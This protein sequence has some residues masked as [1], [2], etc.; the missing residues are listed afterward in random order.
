MRHGLQLPIFFLGI[1]SIALACGDPKLPSEDGNDDVGDGDGDGDGD[2]GSQLQLTVNKD[3][4]ILFVIDNTGSMGEEQARL[5]TSVGAFIDVLE[6]P[7]VA[8]NYRIGVTTTDNGNPWCPAGTTTPEAGKLV[9]SSCKNRLGDFLFSDTVDVQDLACNDICTLSDAELEIIPTTTDYD[10]NQV[11]RPWLENI[12][13]EKN[14]PAN[15]SMADACRWF[16]SPLESMYLSLA[17]A[18]N[19]NEANYGFLRPTAILAIVIVSDEADCSYNKDFADIFAQD[20][21]KVFWSDPTASFPTSAV[22]WNAGVECS[23]D[24]SGYDSCEPVN[25]DVNGTAGVSDQDAVLHPMSRYVGRIQGIEDQKKEYNAT[26]EVITVLIGGVASDGS[27]VYADAIDP[28]FQD[29]FGIGPGCTD[30]G[31]ASAVPPVRMRSFTEAFSPESMYSICESDYTPAFEAIADAI[32]DQIK[33]ACY[34]QCAADTM[35]ATEVID[36][37]CVVEEN[38]PALE[39]AEIEECMRNG[40]GSYAIDPMTMSHA[41]PSDAVNVCYALR[42]DTG[43]QTS[44]PADNMSPECLGEGYNLEFAIERRPGFP[45]KGGTAV[46][47]TCSLSASPQVDCPDLG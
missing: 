35:P 22:C 47:A 12:E 41:M 13:G 18:E 9:L 24:P 23:G 20:G 32:R 11:Q 17:R 8:V 25:K 36:P 26:Q 14:I 42:V 33:P 10:P 30:A 40:D 39:P 43:G 44:D 16:E 7:E 29:S 4:D 45:A 21:N 27:V 6:N 31:G 46:S 15:T 1:V 38:A 5:A 28:A 34:K 2:G 3:V 19:E 37:D